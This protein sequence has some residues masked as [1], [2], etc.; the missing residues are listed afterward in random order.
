MMESPCPN[1][2]PTVTIMKSA[3]DAFFG[4]LEAFDGSIWVASG[5]RSVSL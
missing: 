3:R 2:K 5:K 1:K 4:I